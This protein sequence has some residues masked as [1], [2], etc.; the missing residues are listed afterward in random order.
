MSLILGP[1]EKVLRDE[2]GVI[3]HSGHT[4]YGNP[5]F[6]RLILTNK[7]FLFVEM[8]IVKVGLLRKKIEY[9]IKGI[10][11]NI[12]IEKVLGT[13]IETR[14]RKKGTLNSPP[15]LFS[16]EQYSVLIVSMEDATGIENPVFEVQNPQDWA[17]AIQRVL[18]GELL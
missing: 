10:K 9:H 7:R 2:V 3:Y 12:P 5:M 8:E 17:N 1:G 18:A 13:A 15:G 14:V 4:R 16:K 11:I 6:G